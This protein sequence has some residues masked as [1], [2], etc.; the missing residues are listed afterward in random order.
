MSILQSDW[1]DEV[2]YYAKVFS[3]TGQPCHWAPKDAIMQHPE[4]LA[5]QRDIPRQHL[6]RIRISFHIPILNS[7]S[8]YPSSPAAY[9]SSSPYSSP[10]SSSQHLGKTIPELGRWVP[11]VLPLHS[12]TQHLVVKCMIFLLF[13]PTL[14]IAKVCMFLLRLGWGNSPRSCDLYDGGAYE[15]GLRRQIS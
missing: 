13:G 6:Q 2:L 12:G 4:R 1:V 8:L 5:S 7:S 11:V 9:N 10:G 3:S 14:K 15:V